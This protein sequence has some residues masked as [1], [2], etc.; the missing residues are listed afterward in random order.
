LDDSSIGFLD[1]GWTPEPALVT[2]IQRWMEKWF[3]PTAITTKLLS[4]LM[5]QQI[6]FKVQM[7]WKESQHQKH[8][9]HSSLVIPSLTQSSSIFEQ[10]QEL[11][12]FHFHVTNKY[13]CSGGNCASSFP[14]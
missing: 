14:Q 7:G 9:S 3:D 6:K 10:R 2:N 11:R 5:R 1:D 13:N 12:G 8:H 4:F